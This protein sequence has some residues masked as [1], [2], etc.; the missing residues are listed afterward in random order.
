MNESG[1]SLVTNKTIHSS[2]GV[3]GVGVFVGVTVFVGVF[4]GVG[5]GVGV[6]DDVTDIVGVIDGVADLV[7]VIGGVGGGVSGGGVGVIHSSLKLGISEYLDAIKL[8]LVGPKD[9]INELLS[10]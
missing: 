1:V 7:G 2:G 10:V 8:T 6:I 3:V 9:V 5:G 4:D